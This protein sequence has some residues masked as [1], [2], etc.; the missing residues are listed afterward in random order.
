MA[1]HEVHIGPSGAQPM[2]IGGRASALSNV[3]NAV[4]GGGPIG[5]GSRNINNSAYQTLDKN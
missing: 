5:V 2:T 4:I 3:G 1:F